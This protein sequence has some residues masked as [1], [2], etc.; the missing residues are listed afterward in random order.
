MLQPN[1]TL[2]PTD[3]QHSL[4][5]KLTQNFLT[6]SQKYAPLLKLEGKD[7]M[8]DLPMHHFIQL[9]KKT[10]CDVFRVRKNP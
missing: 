4:A 9:E 6:I 7:L 3:F 10:Y 1:S 8:I 2:S 5:L